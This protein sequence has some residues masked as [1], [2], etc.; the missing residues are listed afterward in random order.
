MTRI[1]RNLPIAT[2]AFAILRSTCLAQSG[3]VKSEGQV[4]QGA[5]V[6]AT[7]GDRILMTLT[8][9]SGTFHFDRMT[10]GSWIVEVD[11]FG[12]EHARKEVQIGAN[13][14]KV[15][16]TL[17]LRERIRP[18]ARTQEEVVETETTAT[19][20]SAAAGSPP[21]IP[22]VPVDG[23]NE[24]FLVNGSLSQGLQTQAGDLRQDFGGLGGLGGPG[25]FGAPPGGNPAEGPG[26]GGLQAG[27]AP[28]GRAGP[29][30]GPGSFGGR[31]GFGGGGFG[32]GG[33]G[34][35]GGGFG[36]G[37]GGGGGPR[38]RSGN[39]AFIGN[40]RPNNNRITG[41]LFYRIGNSA[42]NARPFSVNGL[43]EPKAAYGQNYFGFSAGGPLFIPKLFRADKVF[44]FIN[45][46]GTRLRNGVDQ[47]YTVP[48]A[49]ERLGNFAAIPG[50]QLYMPQ[51]GAC[52]AL[53][54][55]RIPANCISPLAQQ[56]LQYVPLPNQPGLTRNYRL[57]AS[58]PSNT[59]NLNARVNTNLTQQNTL[60]VAFNLQER[61]SQTFEPYGCCN[62]TDG[63]GI[64]TNVNWRHRFGNRSFNVLRL[65]FNRNTTT[66]VP[67][68]TDN[69]TSQIA[70]DGAS[71]DPRN[72]GPPN[73]SFANLS[74]LSGSNW[75]KTATW[76]YGASDALQLHRGAHN[77][78]FGG[79]YTHYLNN[80]IGDANGRGAF[81]FAGLATAQYVNGLP[82]ANTGNDFADFLLGLPETSSISH[83]AAGV[84]SSYFRSNLYNA[85]VMDDWRAASNFTLNLGVRYEYFTPWQEKYGH[86]ANLDIA[87]GF[88]AVAPVTP[89]QTGP[90]SGV[91][92]P[93]ALIRPDRNDF[94]PRIG[95]AW[96]PGARSKIVVRAGYGIYYTPNQY[97]RFQSSLAGQ[98]PF[99]VTNYI[100]TSS[101]NVLTLSNG[102]LAVP[103]G[104][105][106]TNTFGVALNYNDTYI[107]SWNLSVQ[108]DLPGRLVGEVVYSGS[109]TT[110]MDVQQAPNQAP[111]GS[112]LTAEQRLPIA[113][114][115]NFIFDQ[116]VGNATYDAL[117]L[118]LT[119]RFQRGISTNLLYTYSKA[120]D[121]A[122]LAQNFYDQSAEK[123]LSSFDH[124]QVLGLNWVL[125]SP[126]DAT[127][128]FL[129][130]PAWI[131]KA[132]KD[133]TISGSITAQS[134]A[135]L[136]ALVTGNLAG[137]ASIA[138][139]RAD[140]TGLSVNSGS[141]YFNPA[142]F[143]VPA[144]GQFGTAGRNTITGPGTFALN[145]SL[146]RSINLHS[147]RR[148]LEFR[149]D[150]Y[151]A[152][153]HVNPSGLITVVNSS[154]FGLITS[155][156]QMR[157]VTATLR[158][159]F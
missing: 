43:P 144:A 63:Q 7:Q 81:G 64:N 141:G 105:T 60:A 89:G 37:R 5:T 10:P 50:V 46:N 150:A 71:A 36:G 31:G 44:W 112:A 134:G 135:P 54:G 159:R 137:T 122:V 143:A 13:A 104:K 49:A 75:S 41:S 120:I 62:A 93:A 2:I 117:Q 20:P 94:G 149:I 106:I 110:N 77:W 97:N 82:V 53:S 30:G 8:D 70:I 22:Q 129:S 45:Y 127:N 72:F 118:R 152:L 96:K 6:K 156:G 139:L 56:M 121:D 4:I 21:E 73:L 158:L 23:S 92:Y 101:A 128:G 116:P 146:A 14:T 24:S 133:W 99:A 19:L 47:S 147:E 136:T 108:R 115:G 153:N 157:Q 38:D 40:R 109:K 113:N 65:A 84:L 111:L 69:V 86:I 15:D 107:Q 130:H 33:F 145:L 114:A 124:R 155:A 90:L 42:L 17:Q 26:A 11:M 34:G 1:V 39:P 80:A 9:D 58:N 85:F 66:G 35:R 148:R 61:N 48:T 138:P 98:A 91:V 28:G 76:N 88:T 132:L 52:P 18:G 119:R 83:G 59:Q 100:T 102:L 25:G 140:A 125:A 103:A 79:A 126:V 74:G 29:G 12:F 95:I 32:G 123:A 51:S 87:P 27:A 57:I 154:Q 131:A 67:F 16:F 55:N 151:N 68:F 78:S 142:A 3:V